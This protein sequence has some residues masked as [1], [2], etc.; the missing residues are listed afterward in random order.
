MSS[1]IKI[2]RRFICLLAVVALV[3]FPSFL[4]NAKKKNGSSQKH[5]LIVYPA[6]P[7]T[8]RVQYLTSINNS[9]FFG[10]RSGFASFILGQAPVSNIDKPY[11]IMLRNGRLVI[12]D[13]VITGFEMFDFENKKFST[14]VPGGLGQL[15]APLNCYVDSNNWIYVADP[16]R[17]EVVVF[18]SF[19]NYVNKFGDTGEFKPTEVTMFDNKIWVTNPGSH[20]INIYDKKTYQLIGHF[21]E[22]FEPGD[23][24]F[25]YSPF[26]LCITSTRVYVTDFG[27]FKVKI[28]DL[29]GKYIKSIG[30]YGT[31][32]GQFVRPK[33]IA[34]DKDEILYVVDAG[35]ENVQM[36]NKEGQLLMF[37]GGTYQG[38]GD[39]WLPAKV[40]LDYDNLKYFEKYVD[41][42]FDLKYLIFVSNQYGPD[43]INVYGAVS[44]KK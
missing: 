10:K 11:G 29:S 16:G 9:E 4:S 30:S 22:H 26:N 19:K 42:N 35:F 6:P 40:Y 5:D 13:P 33:G 7:D 2:S 8:P 36:F 1:E 43:R 18:D 12:C 24:G 28:Y 3:V 17:H 25:L 34:C 41:H 23:D 21:P 20:T 32:I 14:F 27:D 15:K 37:F 38:P 31:N 39:M 44:P